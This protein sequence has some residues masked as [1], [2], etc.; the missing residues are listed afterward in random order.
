M[1]ACSGRR[2]VSG[3]NAMMRRLPG[4]KFLQPRWAD[5]FAVECS[6]RLTAVRND[7]G[8]AIVE[9]IL[10]A[11]ILISLVFGIIALSMAMYSLHFVSYAAREGTRYA[12]VRGS[13]CPGILPGCPAPGSGVDVQTYLRGLTYPGINTNKMTVTTTWSGGG[14]ACTPSSAPCDNPGN[15]V[16]VTVSYRF[17]LNIPYLP[18]QTLTMT[19]TSEM[20]ISQ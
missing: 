14:T 16:H 11:I 4:R 15:L 1:A 13:S 19:S 10:S 12:I 9:F 2:W 17:P 5:S 8:A 3:V 7:E 6:R 18:S 20:V